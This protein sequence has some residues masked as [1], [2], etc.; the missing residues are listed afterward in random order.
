HSSGEVC[1]EKQGHHLPP[2]P[3]RRPWLVLAAPR[4]T[5][6]WIALTDHEWA[7]TRPE[8]RQD[9]LL[10]ALR[11]RRRRYPPAPDSNRREPAHDRTRL[12]FRRLWA[13][14]LLCA[15]WRR[16]EYRL[17]LLRSPKLGARR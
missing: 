8:G 9:S 14:T 7:C 4:E 10:V 13:G 6:S 17:T 2:Q 5:A 11:P 16:S 1:S 3:G 15:T 12:P